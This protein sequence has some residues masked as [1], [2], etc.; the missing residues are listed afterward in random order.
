MRRLEI[1]LS[2]PP[3]VRNAVLLNEELAYVPKQ[4]RYFT[5]ATSGAVTHS[6]PDGY[7]VDF[8]FLF[9]KIDA[10]V[11]AVTV[12]AYTGQSINGLSSVS[13]SSQ[14]SLITI[15]FCRATGVWILI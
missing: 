11:N 1:I 6:L 4:R 12:V 5:D 2:D 14:Y 10:S 8:D 15:A 9:V 13:L 3:A 7:T